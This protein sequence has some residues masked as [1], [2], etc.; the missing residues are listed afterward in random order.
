MK[1]EKLMN[2]FATDPDPIEMDPNIEAPRGV[3]F[4]TVLQSSKNA[5]DHSKTDILGDM[6]VPY[7]IEIKLYGQDQDQADFL[8]QIASG[9]K[10]K[11]ELSKY[12]EQKKYLTVANMPLEVHILSAVA[13]TEMER[14]MPYKVIVRLP[15]RGGGHMAEQEF[16]EA[17]FKAD[18]EGT[19]V[20]KP[21]CGPDPNSEAFLEALVGQAVQDKKRILA[22]PF[23]I[24]RGSIA[25]PKDKRLKR[26]NHFVFK[27][28]SNDSTNMSVSRAHA[29]IVFKDGKYYLLDSGSGARTYVER[30]A[31]SNKWTEAPDA[32]G[33]WAGVELQDGDVIRLGVEG[34]EG[35]LRLPGTRAKVRFSLVRK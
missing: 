1:I 33:Q 24:G 16:D 30:P 20:P 28:I 18:D 13:Q 5:L 26:D 14:R 4:D 23:Y 21:T 10:F 6:F 11:A 15:K 12:L 29:E 34:D 7:Y 17:T 3:N 27:K 31:G 32:K 2:W 9:T 19:W 25:Q 35:D 22:S 8:E